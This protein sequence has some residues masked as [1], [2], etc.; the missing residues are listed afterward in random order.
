[1]QRIRIVKYK[2]KSL[3]GEIRNEVGLFTVSYSISGNPLTGN[4]LIPVSGK[5]EDIFE[6]CNQILKCV[7]LPILE[8]SYCYEEDG[9][10]YMNVGVSLIF[11]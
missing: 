8:T 11:E 4:Q 7:E 1:M 9:M 2:F 6:M 10:N 3:E 5:I